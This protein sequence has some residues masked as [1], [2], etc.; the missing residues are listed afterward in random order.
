MTQEMKTTLSSTNFDNFEISR[1]AI[2]T[3]FGEL[4]I[5]SSSNIHNQPE[6]LN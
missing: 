3:I 6:F 1:P 5:V 4:S 2:Q